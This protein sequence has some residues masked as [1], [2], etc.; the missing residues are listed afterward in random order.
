MLSCPGAITHTLIRGHKCCFTQVKALK[1]P[2]VCFGDCNTV[3]KIILFREHTGI[4]RVNGASVSTK[5]QGIFYQECILIPKVIDPGGS[6]V[7]EQ[8]LESSTTQ[9]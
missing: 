7:P 6:M 3:V 2:L 8:R 1:G 5:V 9:S 4:A